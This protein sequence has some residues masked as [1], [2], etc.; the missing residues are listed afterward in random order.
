SI[1]Q[2]IHIYLQYTM[3]M[4]S[5]GISELEL[6][7][8]FNPDNHLYTST[9]KLVS[10]LN[11]FLFMLL[12]TTCF[13]IVRYLYQRFV[14]KP[15]ALSFSIRKSN[16]PRFLENGW[17][18]L[19]Y[20]TFQLFGFYV[21]FKEEWTLFPTMNIWLGW[22]IQPFSTLFR[23][24]YLLELSFY[25]HCTIALFFETR[26]KDFNQMITHHLATFFLVGASYWFRYQRIGL[27]ILITHNLGDIFL[28]SAKALNYIQKEKMNP[29]VYSVTADTLFILFAITFFL[30]RLVFFPSVLIRTTMFE[31][32]FVSTG[33][34]LY[35]S[36]NVAL[37]TL[38]CLHIFWFYLILR[39]II[40]KLKKGT[41]I[42][43]IRSDSDEEYEANEKSHHFD[44][45]HLL[46]DHPKSKARAAAV[47]SRNSKLRSSKIKS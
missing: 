30:T 28:Y 10:E 14:L 3:T 33:F 23:T 44:A 43:D 27:I 46:R 7:R 18:S 36:T 35:Y 11:A 2:S 5:Y 8:Y 25:F 45:E 13:F 17:Y 16:V 15:I 12:A 6:E 22:P 31:A 32:F 34:P 47:N 4:E 42:D 26:R 21:F 29:E 38:Q 20:I 24:Y 41:K 19:Y 39:I 37:V 1:K 9:R 40:A